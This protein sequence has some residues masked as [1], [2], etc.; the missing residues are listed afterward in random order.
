MKRVLIV[1]DKEDNL[2]Y[3]QSLLGGHGCEVDFARHGAEALVRARHSPPDLVITDLLMPVMDGYTLL[4]HWRSDDDLRHVPFVVYT[5]T[6][7]EPEDER[8]ALQLGADAFILKPSEPDDF[9]AALEQAIVGAREAGEPPSP[10]E[11][12]ADV[13]LLEKYSV[14]LIRK[15]EEKTFQLEEANRALE[16]DMEKAKEMEASLRASEERLATAQHIAK[17]GSWEFDWES[18][19]F[20]CSGE[21]HRIYEIDPS[22]E[23]PSLDTFRERLHPEDREEVERAIESIDQT[24]GVREIRHRLLMEAGR[25]KYVIQRWKVYHERSGNPAKVIGTTR[26]ITERSEAER[27]FR[28]TAHLLRAVADGTSDAVF[29]KDRKGRY[30]FLN[31]AAARFMGGS[32]DELTGK[33]DTSIFGE[34]DV[35]VI[36]Q[37]DEEVMQSGESLTREEVLNTAEGTITF[38]A[39]KAPHRDAQ[40]NVIGVVGIS[41]DITEQK[42]L[43]SQFLRVQRLESIGTLAGGIAHDL[44]NVLSPIMMSIGLLRATEQDPERLDILSTIEESA[45][46][47]ADMVKQ[48]LSFARGVEGRHLHVEVGNLLREIEKF[49]NETF[50]KNIRVRCHYPDDLWIVGGDPTQLHQVVLNLGSGLRDAMPGGGTLDIAAENVELDDHYAAMN[51]EATPGPHV[52]IRVDDTG[53]GMPPEIIDRIFEPFYTTKGPGDGTGLG[54]STTLAIVKSHGGFLRIE[55]EVGRGTRFNVYLPAKPDTSAE[56]EPPSEQ[57]LIERGEGELILVVD[58][59]SSIREIT[60]HTLEEYGYAVM[61][62][63]DGAEA[64]AIYAESR[65]RIDAVIMDMMMPNMDGPS[66]VRAILRIDPEARIIAASGLTVGEIEKRML[67]AGVKDFIPKPYTA[68]TLLRI[69]HHVLEGRPKS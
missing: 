69:L 31:Q 44:N 17:M 18:N 45:R 16:A 36:R 35:R 63:R 34:E 61:L 39:T 27:K 57:D 3:L 6:Y 13:E 60:K 20:S 4:R 11:S 62:A 43:E 25:T 58:D 8:L 22:N 68:H 9:L 37:S 56:D 26:D 12:P 30:L 49:A 23:P 28:Q 10:E 59:E 40:G 54:L 52:L 42:E 48:V 33:N 14:A 2:Y 1:D 41:R 55:S 21:M 46:H 64:T 66:A 5:A 51:I 15:L 53:T 24:E 38:S 19:E 32:V 7:T 29:V 65:D 50:L 47:G 67:E